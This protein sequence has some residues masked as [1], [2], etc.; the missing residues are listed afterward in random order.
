MLYLHVVTECVKIS[1]IPCLLFEIIFQGVSP[2]TNDELLGKCL[3]GRTQNQN[4]SFN[5]TVWLRAPKGTYVGLQQ[6]EIAVFDA[7]SHFNIGSKAAVLTYEKLGIRPGN[8]MIAGCIKKNKSEL[9]MLNDIARKP[10]KSVDVIYGLPV[11]I[12]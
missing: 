6:L 5:N 2:L 4:E 7:V 1:V 8:N 3:H 10:I 11:R 9:L 12:K